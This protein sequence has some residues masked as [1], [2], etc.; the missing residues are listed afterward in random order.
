[1]PLHVDVVAA[2]HMVWSGEAQ[3]VVAR[4][5]DGDLGILPGHT[6]VLALLAAGEFT[7]TPVQGDPVTASL[8]GGFLSVEHDRVTVVSGPA[9]VMSGSTGR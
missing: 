9:A 1:M 3:M 6:P 5:S 7:V 2:D 8:E 4:T